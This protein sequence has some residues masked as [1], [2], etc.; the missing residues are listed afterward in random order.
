MILG[1]KDSSAAA[2]YESAMDGEKDSFATALYA[3]VRLATEE[4]LKLR[5][6]DPSGC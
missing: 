2:P 4:N 5:Q 6:L 3:L 1:E